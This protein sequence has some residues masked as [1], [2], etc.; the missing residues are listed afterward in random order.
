MNRRAAVLLAVAS[1]VLAPLPVVAHRGH[2]ALS[3]V[4]ID[5]K[6]GAVT[7]THRIPAH[8]AEPALAV[9]APDAQAS[10]DDPD[11]I[12]ALKTYMAQRFAVAVSGAPVPLVLKDM[13]L[14]ADEVRLEYVGKITPGDISAEITVRAAMFA[15]VYGD[16]VNQVNVRRLGVT[17]TLIFNGSEAAAPQTLDA[18]AP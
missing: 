8:D 3:V 7:V 4:E 11:A 16:Q 14:G 12:E 9:I 10:L 18:L 17:R 2:G 6:T 15:D 1:L 5:G 13:T